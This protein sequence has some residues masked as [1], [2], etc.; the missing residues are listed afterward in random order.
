MTPKLTIVE[1]P[2]Q[3]AI[4]TL[5]SD[6]LASR[7]ADG[8]SARTIGHYS[9]CL[10]QV[11]LPWC[12]GEGITD[13]GQLTV[14]AASR[15]SAH[16]LE[17]GGSRGQ[18][19]SRATVR[20]YVQVAR[21]FLGWA[22]DPEG[23]AAT[24]GA[25]PKLPKKVKVM[26]DVLSRDEIQRMENAA[27]TE[28]DKLIVRILADCG[29][30]LGELL[31]LRVEDIWEQRKG[32]FFLKV[33]GKGSKDRLVPLAPKLR[34]RLRQY[35]AGRHAEPHDRLFL[36]LRRKGANG[37][38]ASLTISGAEQCVHLAAEEAGIT[39]RVYPHLLRHSFATEWL[40][41]GGNVISLRN[42][43]GHFD[44][45]MIQGVYS[46]LDTS[47]DYKATMAVLLGQE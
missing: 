7:R 17:D 5:A 10:S 1:T 41:R 20:S 3:T 16:L 18:P 15:F 13:P 32:E 31:G 37:D 9:N 29:L 28:R 38:Y 8:L 27:K 14:Q 19:L 47:D 46:H 30:R 26:V 35:L 12:A 43:L 23:G 40:R 42:V 4:S 36:S 11:F 39:K 6:F 21:V 44:L 2:T 22:A 34:Q 45:S 24:V 33:T 25:S